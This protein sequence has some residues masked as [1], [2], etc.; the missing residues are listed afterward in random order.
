MKT[1]ITRAKAE[2]IRARFPNRF[3]YAHDQNGN[4]RLGRTTPG[5]RHASNPTGRREKSR[6]A[7]HSFV[8]IG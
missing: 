6:K 4:L 5:A 3:G 7:H 1:H 2:K 8:V